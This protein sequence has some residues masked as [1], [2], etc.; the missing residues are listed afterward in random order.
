MLVQDIIGLMMA[1]EGEDSKERDS[2][3]QAK[4]KGKRGLEPDGPRLW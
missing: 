3:D 2:K 4:V 1:R